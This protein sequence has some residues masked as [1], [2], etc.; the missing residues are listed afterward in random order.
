[1]DGRIRA[2]EVRVVDTDG[3]NVGVI[4]L[5]DALGLAAKRG[6][7]L[8]EVAPNATPPVCRIVDIGKYRYEIAKKEKESKKHQ[9]AN[10]IK[11]LKFHI[12]ISEHDYTIKLQHAEDWLRQGYKVK[13]SVFFRGRE[14]THQNLGLL[15]LQRFVKDCADFAAA[16]SPPRLLGRGLHV[17]LTARATKRKRSLPAQPAAAPAKLNSMSTSQVAVN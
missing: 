4:S 6:L 3:E 1:M 10:K 16:V 15:R 14:M 13:A 12:N 5:R 7:N 2:R 11:E 9:H 8:V 17:M